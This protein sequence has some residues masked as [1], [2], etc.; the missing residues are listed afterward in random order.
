MLVN[1]KEVGHLILNGEVFDKS[2]TGKKVITINEIVIGNETINK[3][4]D[5]WPSNNGGVGIPAN[6]SCTILT[7]YLNCFYI[8]EN[9]ENSRGFWAKK[10]DIKILD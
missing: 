9:L 3:E 6:T 7:H 2:Y 5:Y 10:S 1:G 8:V 4:G